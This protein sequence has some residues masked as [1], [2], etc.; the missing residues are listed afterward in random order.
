M[1]RHGTDSCY[2]GGCRQPE[3]KAAHSAAVRERK[4]RREVGLPNLR[5]CAQWVACSKCGG[6]IEHCDGRYGDWM[7][8]DTRREL[9]ADGHLARPET[10]EQVVLRVMPGSRRA[11]SRAS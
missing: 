6:E 7:H 2:T 4:R 3:C 11:R 5:K 8:S 10:V 9:G 1:R